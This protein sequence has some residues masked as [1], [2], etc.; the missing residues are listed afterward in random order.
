MVYQNCWNFRL[1]TGK[2]KEGTGLKLS[3]RSRY[4]LEGMLY[5]AVY[6]EG[7]PV[8]VKEISRE[9]GISTAYLEQIFFLLKKAGLTATVRGSHGGFVPARP[10]QEITAGMIVR[11]IDGEISPVNCVSNP[12]ECAPDRMADCPTRPLW[13]KAAEAISGTLDALTLKDLR[14]GFLKE[15][16]AEKT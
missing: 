6:G 16:E 1:Y 3:T 14:C 5:L 13:V 10:L 15:S 7:R 11:T 4:A 2:Q 8:P 9:T 12:E